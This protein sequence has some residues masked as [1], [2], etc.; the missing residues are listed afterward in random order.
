MGVKETAPA[1]LGCPF[2]WEADHQQG[3]KGTGFPMA[4]CALEELKQGL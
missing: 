4:V 3:H 2:W 1:P